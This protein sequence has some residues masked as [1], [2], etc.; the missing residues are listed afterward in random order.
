MANKVIIEAEARFTDNISGPAKQAQK[1]IDELGKAVDALQAKLNG[2][3][4]PS[5]KVP[6]RTPGQGGI[7]GRTIPGMPGQGTK[8]KPYKPIFDADNSKF[9]QKLRQMENK[10][11]A[12]GKNKTA[13]VLEAVDKAT[14][15]IG[16]VMNA[17]QK[18]GRGAYQ[19][20]L[21]VSDVGMRV[22]DKVR[23]GLRSVT[24]KVWTATLRV[25]DFVT[26]PIRKLKD[27]L[28]SIKGLV[29]AIVAGA[30]FNK[31]VKQPVGMYADYEDLVTQFGVLLG[32]Q[33]AA[34]K[35]MQDLVDFAGKTPFTRDKIFQAS[36]ILQTYTNGALATPDATGG[37]KM[38]GDVAAATGEDYTRVANYFG[39]LYNEVARGGEAL[40]EPLMLL[41]EIGA[42]SAEN[43][44][45]ITKIAQGSGTI[46]EKWSQIA[47]QFSKTDGMMEAMSNQM[48]NLMLGVKSFVKNNLWMKLGEGIS[49][50]LKPFLADFRTWR[51]ENGALI[52]EWAT[53]IKDTAQILSGK[54]LG[55]VQNIASKVQGIMKTPEWAEAGIGGKAKMLWK[56]LI[57]DPLSE[58]W[59]GGG[60]EKTIAAAGKIGA[61]AGSLLSKAMLGLFRGIAGLTGKG[62]GMAEA[63]AEAGSSVAGAFIN[64]FLDNFDRGAVA[65]AFKDAVSG[66]WDV[67]PATGKALVGLFLGSKVIG[68]GAKVLGGLK[69]FWGSAGTLE[70]AAGGGAA[71]VGASGLRG[72]IGR[73]GQIRM[74]GG[75]IVPVGTSGLL[76]LGTKAFYKAHAAS[77]VLAAT[78]NSALATTLGLSGIAGG[79]IGGATA[80]KGGMDVYHGI[81]EDDNVKQA[82]GMMKLGGVGAGALTGAAIG[83]FVPVLGTAL[84]A[85]I[86]AGVG[87]LASWIGSSKFEKSMKAADFASQEM[88][89]ALNDSSKSADEIDATFRKVV[90]QNLEDHFG[91]IRLSMDE[92]SRLSDQLVW[93]DDKAT[94][95]KFTNAA[96]DAQKS[97]V[98]LNNAGKQTEKWMWKAS[99]GVKFDETEQEN[100][101]ASFQS[102]IDSAQGYIENQHYTFTAAV[103]VLFEP[104]S[105]GREG[106]LDSGGKWYTETEKKAKELGEQL[107]EKIETALKGDGVITDQEWEAIMKVQVEID[108]ITGQVSEAEEQARRMM[109]DTMFKGGKLK[110]GSG[111]LDYTSYQRLMEMYDTGLGEK[112]TGYYNSTAETLAGINGAFNTGQITPEVRT[113]QITDTFNAYKAQIAGM[114]GEA[115]DFHVD[116]ISDTYANELGTDAATKVREALN[117]ALTSHTDPLSWSLSDIQNMFGLTGEN[118]GAVAGAIQ[119]MLGDAFQNL[120][121]L[122]VDDS[123]LDSWLDPERWGSLDPLDVKRDANV[124]LEPG[125]IDTSALDENTPEGLTDQNPI[126]TERPVN[127]TYVP[128]TT[129]TGPL[130]ATTQGLMDTLYGN[131]TVDQTITTNTT[132]VEGSGNP[133]QLIQDKVPDSVSSTSSL[134]VN[135]GTKILGVANIAAQI[136]AKVPKSVSAT[137]TLTVSVGTQITGGGGGRLDGGRRQRFRGGIVGGPSAMESYARGGIV[138][139]SDGGMVRGGSRLIQVA[140]EGSPEMVIPLSS[141]RRDR[142]RKLWEKAGEM[143]KV[144]GFAQGGLTGGGSIEPLRPYDAAT[145]SVSPGETR[146]EVGGVTVQITV[147]AAPGGS[148]ADEVTSRRDEIVDTVAAAIAEALEAGFANTPVRGGLAG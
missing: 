16:K 130:S 111:A 119:Q 75:Q 137:T 83:S 3:T 145:A 32:S 67:L 8:V 37:L 24:S 34:K 92:I 21:K 139:Y 120:N 113:Q 30:T 11:R 82:S 98:A 118:S 93:G 47:G 48:N 78:T 110:L 132:V 89:D 53:R 51:N 108:D 64:G 9:L 65:G 109:M 96:N 62:S 27:S 133:E 128:G 84:G 102:Y 85:A 41:R 29:T 95:E 66:I 134:A 124:T 87:G 140:E 49:A 28:F 58:W 122:E 81:K 104:D 146:I 129:D 91:D 40:G 86:G 126:E 70:T 101:K 114:R 10:A 72:L 45:A 136:K 5:M 17:A 15:V 43:E 147:Q 73:A 105:P 79:V 22:V 4:M 18:F 1:Q 117:N 33:D 68:G 50:S 76:G 31:A 2:T 26:A 38:I 131:K 88:K 138:G 39:R 55:A 63:G 19:A 115:L 25:K 125:E 148:V 71:V 142:G 14:T 35:R 141:Q 123:L 7:P 23:S 99:L 74:Q 103:D 60:R 46:E 56:G 42:I 143:L 20:E 116:L 94:F 13:V 6:G 107:Q 106:I 100:I 12:L 57:T 121:P 97:L 144:P 61:E 36:R 52:S 112:Q 127:T 90:A 77:P 54:V 44:E 80:I 135:V 59:N 69:S